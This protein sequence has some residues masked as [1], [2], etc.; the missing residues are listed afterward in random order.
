ML[1]GGSK[2]IRIRK[3]CRDPPVL[4]PAKNRSASVIGTATDN[5]PNFFS[6]CGFERRKVL[7]I[8]GARSIC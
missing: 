6:P 4:R 3:R 1:A 8:F 7:L 2:R 5:E